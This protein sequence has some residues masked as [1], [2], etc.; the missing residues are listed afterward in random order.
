MQDN[1]TGIHSNEFN[2]LMKRHHTSKLSTFDDLSRVLT[3]G[4]RGE[5]LSSL[6]AVTQLSISTKHD[7]DASSVCLKYDHKGNVVSN[8]PAAHP[9]GTTVKCE[10]LFGNFSVRKKELAKN[11]KKEFTKCCNMIQA[12]ALI[13][14]GVRITVT[15]HGS[16]S[17]SK[18]FVVICNLTVSERQIMLSSSGK[19]LRD[20][21]ASIY[22]AKQF[23]TLTP[24]ALTVEKLK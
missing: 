5:A 14:D 24:V 19:S 1:G 17:S 16:S 2:S 4:F 11:I 15:C 21:I 7:E 13:A 23:A 22:G 3:Y 20:N 18:R 10:Q 9:R 12:Y 6:A 8:T